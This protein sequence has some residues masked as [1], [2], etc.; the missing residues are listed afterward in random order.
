M[1]LILVEH[2]SVELFSRSSSIEPILPENT[3]LIYGGP[4]WQDSF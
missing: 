4:V 3:W 1:R 2:S